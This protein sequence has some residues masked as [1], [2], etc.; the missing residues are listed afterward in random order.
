MDIAVKTLPQD[1]ACRYIRGRIR[2]DLRIS[3][4]PGVYG[5]KIVLRL[6]DTGRDDQL[7]DVERMGMVP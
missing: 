3:A 4:V 5:E 7:M 2:A 1:G 6:L